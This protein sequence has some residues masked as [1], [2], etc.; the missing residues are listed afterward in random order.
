MAPWGKRM[1]DF[2][3]K[4]TKLVDLD[5]ILPTVKPSSSNALRAIGWTSVAVGVT[6]LGLYIGREL[7]VR[8]KFKRR[9]PS[10]FFS[11]AGEEF[12]ADYGVG[13]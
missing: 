10:D 5:T 4:S 7:R 8:Y 6:A 1:C 11:H 9:T 3:S 12:G 2:L 13:V